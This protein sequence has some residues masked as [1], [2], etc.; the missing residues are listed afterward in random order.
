MKFI[1]ALLCTTLL[2]AI[3]SLSMAQSVDLGRGALPLTVPTNYS[4]STP[5]PLIVL[6]HGYTSSGANQDAYMGFSKLAD[7]YGFLFVA[8]DGNKEP[9]GDE[10]R[11]WNASPAC[12]DFFSTGVDDSAYVANIIEEVKGVYNVDPWIHFHPG[13]VLAI[14][15]QCGKTVSN[16]FTVRDSAHTHYVTNLKTFGANL[17]PLATFVRGVKA[18]NTTTTTL[19]A[20]ASK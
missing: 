10:N 18:C 9:A 2:L 3:P 11:F 5:M 19:A 7:R 15:S 8:P 17:H 12:C 14:S 16:W 1:K 6:L 13:G 4:A 20:T